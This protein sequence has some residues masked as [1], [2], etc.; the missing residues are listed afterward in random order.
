[1]TRPA[2][3]QSAPGESAPGRALVACDLDQTLIFSRRSFRLP[4]G[5]AEPAV[6]LVERLDGAPLTFCDEVSLE[7]LARLDRSAVFVPATTRTLAQYRRIDLGLRPRYAVAANGGH[8]IV[9]GVPDPVW[10]A[11]VAG[12]LAGGCAP[13][14]EILAL[15]ERLAEDGWARLVRSADDL[16]VYL[17]AHTR[18]A[19]PDLSAV[20]ERV[21]ALGWTLSS[22]GRKVYLVPDGLTKQAAVAEIVRRTGATRLFAAGD[23]VLDLPILT[24]ADRAVRPAHGELHELGWAAPNLTVTAASGLLAA[25]ELLGVLDGWVG[26]PLPAAEV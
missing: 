11:E 18:E 25:R 3:G 26:S 1:M 15:A 23:S 13:L 19:I 14:P 7:L 9:D 5:A 2:P 6:T 17:V 24:A 16:F 22:Q 8:L 12:R 20:A 21:A 4:P 10:A